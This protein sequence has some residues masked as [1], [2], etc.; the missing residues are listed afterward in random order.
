MWPWEHLAVGYLA[1]SALVHLLAR[2]RPRGDEAVA[3]AVATQFPDL[4]DK[5]LA[6][7]L[8]VLPSGTSLAHS[9]AFALPASL[10]A[11]LVAW[12]AGRARVGAAFAVGYLLHLPGDVLYPA[13][14]G[15]SPKTAFLLWPFVP[16]PAG[17]VA[18]FLPHFEA[19]LATFLSHLATPRGTLYLTGELVLLGSVFALYAYDGTPGLRWLRRRARTRRRPASPDE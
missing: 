18:G 8:D 2:R 14:L 13:L 19:L 5:P 11:L 10:V 15:G 17:D 4:I 1:Y 12:R 6:W 16:A 7:S 3:V 9:L